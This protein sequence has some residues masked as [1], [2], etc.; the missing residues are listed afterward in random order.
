MPTR[1]N[2]GDLTSRQLLPEKERSPDESPKHCHHSSC[3]PRDHHSAPLLAY[4]GNP[5]ASRSLSRCV[6]ADKCSAAVYRAPSLGKTGLFCH[7][8]LTANCKVIT[9]SHFRC[10]LSMSQRPFLSPLSS[11]LP[12]SFN[13]SQLAASAVP[14]RHCPL[15]P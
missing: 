12:V 7:F 9:S 10:L 6:N 1:H 4:G 13:L 2:S 11:P 14:I 15:N 5:E 8:A 3:F